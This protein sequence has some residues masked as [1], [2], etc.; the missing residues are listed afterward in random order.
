MKVKILGTGTCVP[1]LQR[2][3]SSYLVVTGQ[4]NILIDVG[5]S[6]VRRL[7][8]CGYTTKDIDAVILT[9]FHVDHTADLSTFLFVSNYDV[10]PRTKEL[11]IIGGEGLHDFYQGL[12]AVYPWLLPKSYEI[13][14]H[15]LREGTLKKSGLVITTSHMEHNNESIGVRIEGDKS[16]VFSGD[17]DYTHKLIELVKETDLLVVECSFP[18][19]KANGHLNLAVVQKVVEQAKPK[20]VIL[21]HLY[22]DWDGYN[23]VLHSPILLG[24]DG[25]E[26]EV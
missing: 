19:K 21:S 14:L 11:F 9:H 13:C 24:E 16:V 15:E 18:E 8:E 2:L 23:G 10:I 22:P 1:S 12:L 17:T 7:L 20:R 26:I 4:A 5:P 25:M 6:V 3:S